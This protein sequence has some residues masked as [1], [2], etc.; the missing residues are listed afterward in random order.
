MRKFIKGLELNQQFYQ[1]VVGPLLKKFKPDLKY[2]AGRIGW[3]SDVLGIDTPVSR[4]HCWGPFLQVFLEEKNFSRTKGALDEFL[5][6]NLPHSFQGYPVG[7]KLVG[8]GAVCSMSSSKEG[9]VRHYFEIVTVRGYFKSYLG[10]DV[11]RP[12]PVVKWFSM[13]EQKL[14]G[15]TSGKLF[16]DD[17]QVERIRKKLSYYPPDVWLSLLAAEW[18]KISEE[19]AFI[20]RCAQLKDELGAQ[21]ITGRLVRSIMKLC[22]LMERR[23]APY[24]KWFGTAFR[25]LKHSKDLQPLL[26]RIF[27]EVDLRKRNNL[28]NQAYERLG[29]LHNRLKI[30]KPQQVMAC[31]IYKRG[32][33]FVTGDIVAAAIRS[34]IRSREVKRF[35]YCLGSIDQFIDCTP[36][37]ENP[38]LQKRLEGIFVRSK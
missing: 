1:Q 19:A 27:R 6:N 10:L 18:C 13:P 32:Y 28:L 15:L 2:S 11:V 21:L 35:N 16:R 37:L 5:R 17:L 26:R 33:K 7:F 31:D 8:V 34:K 30:T 12:I 38:D 24:S 29:E 14:L 9:P 36:I 25:S 22:F 3:G 23:Y 20:G 4:D